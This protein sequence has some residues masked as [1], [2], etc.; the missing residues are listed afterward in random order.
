MAAESHDDDA[1]PALPASSHCYPASTTEEPAQVRTA[2]RRF[3][4]GPLAVPN[5]ARC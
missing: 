3:E 4:R 2:S 1:G 5:D